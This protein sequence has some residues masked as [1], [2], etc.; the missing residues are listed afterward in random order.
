MGANAD[1]YKAIVEGY[2]A[3]YNA[4]DVKAMLGF[5]HLEIVF[6]NVAGGEVNA[7]ATGI[8]EFRE[9]AEQSKSL[10]ASRLQVIA[11][12]DSSEDTARV[13]IKYK[14]VLAADL[15]NGMKA[16]DTLHLNGTSVF[17][18]RDDKLYRIT[19]YS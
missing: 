2:I 6:K 10:F 4:L 16:G 12:F 7:T 18:F 5:L 13:G 11:S 17:K 14:A 19:D 3:A 15:P 8:D 1:R 9:M